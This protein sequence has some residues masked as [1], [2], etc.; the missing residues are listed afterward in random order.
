MTTAEGIIYGSQRTGPR[1]YILILQAP[2]VPCHNGGHKARLQVELGLEETSH[3]LI[4]MAMDAV[5]IFS[6]EPTAKF[7]SGR[8]VDLGV[9]RR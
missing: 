5:I 8:M 9:R 2:E 4:S 6:L 1:H 3:L 7:P